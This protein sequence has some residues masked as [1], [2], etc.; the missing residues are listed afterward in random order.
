MEHEDLL[1]LTQKSITGLY[2]VV[3]ESSRAIIVVTD[4]MKE[5]ETGGQGHISA[6]L[7]HQ[8]AT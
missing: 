1:L 2:E 7:L 4:P 8:C 5:D 3:S 6:S